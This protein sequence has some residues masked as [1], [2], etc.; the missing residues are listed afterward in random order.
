[1]KILFVASE[2]A[3]FAKTGGLADVAG[4][5]PFALQREGHQVS[6]VLPLY[7]RIGENFRQKM[8]KVRE[9]YVDLDWR[10]QY[11]GIYLYQEEGLDVYFIDNEYYFHR[12]ALYGMYDDGERFVFFNKAVVE[13]I[14]E[15]DLQTDIVHANDWHTGLI[16]LYIKDFAK[17]DDY[18][19]NIKTVFTIH[20]LKYQGIF[21]PE[22]LGLAG[23]SREYFHEEGLKY[24]E[25][26]NFMKAGIVYCDALTTVSQSYA[27]E[28]KYEFYGET[29]QGI[30][31]RHEYKL[32]GIINGIDYDLYNPETDK[33]IPHHYS[34][35]DPGGKAKDK[36]ALQRT[37]GLPVREDVPVLSMVSRLVDMKGLDLVRY[38]L[39]ELLQ[40]DIQIVVLGTGEKEYEDMFRHFQWK[41][42]DKMS[43]HIYFNEEEAHLVYAG[44]DIFLM[45]SMAEPCGIS[46]LI[47][48]RYGTVPVVREAGGL[49]DT[50][51]PY[52]EFTQEGTG[53]SFAN[54]NAHE[55]LHTI[56]RAL[57][58]YRDKESWKGLVNR[59]MKAKHD[60]E[61]SSKE[62]TRLYNTLLHQRW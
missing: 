44:S 59:T 42:P 51:I 33:R 19:K 2:M 34:V 45:P 22:I 1:M 47:A 41:Y 29:L 14:R 57:E 32:M 24:Y 61:K 21:P 12:H 62:Y 3:P 10:H 17:G 49:K 7:S 58:V 54:Y 48:L 6:V 16:P 35:E 40:E 46:Q 15:L 60:W 39:D 20:N 53:F 23:I 36:E 50:V 13:M 38:I 28:I 5:L 52:N 37:F 31:R 30:I 56:R 11:A 55:L 4:S 18:Y 43:A 26:V 8:R 25:M 9:F 27:Q